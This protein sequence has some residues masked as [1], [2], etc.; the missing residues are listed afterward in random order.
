MLTAKELRIVDLF[1]KDPFVNFTIR[2]LMS[3]ID[4]RSYSW[5]YQAIKKLQKEKIVL[6]TKKGQ[7]QLCS[8]N[9]DEPRS[10]VYL[11]LLE[12]LNALG[13]KI[14]NLG[15]LIGIMPAD[16]HILIIG[17]SYADNT[18]TKKSD[19]DVVVIIDKKEEKKWLLNKLSSEGDLMI[20]HLHAYVFTKDE[21]LEM[22]IN[23]EANYGKEIERKHLIISGAELYFKILKEAMESG[24]KR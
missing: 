24:Y 11:S 15:K 14:P 7:G 5:T 22:L 4:T 20:P 9:L 1:R 21:F 23:K 10:I 18:F 8:I 19:M 17:G 3:H 6:L 13:K 16:F 12:E 2:K